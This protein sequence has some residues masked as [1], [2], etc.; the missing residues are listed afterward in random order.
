M[1]PSPIARQELVASDA[2][3]LVRRPGRDLG[4]TVKIRE[5]SAARCSILDKS[6]LT[7]LPMIFVRVADVQVSGEGTTEQKEA[8]MN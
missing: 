3:T 6:M 1:F 8:L 4:E 5:G 7:R 2:E